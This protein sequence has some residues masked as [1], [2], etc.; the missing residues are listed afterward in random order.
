M[1]VSNFQ[2]RTVIRAY[3]RNMRARAESAIDESVEDLPEDTVMLS[4]QAL[5]RRFFGRI[6]ERVA[7]KARGRDQE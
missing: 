7:E 3:V 2:I 6:G 4:E 5:R 1:T